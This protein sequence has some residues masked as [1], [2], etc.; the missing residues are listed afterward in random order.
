MNITTS[1]LKGLN[2]AQKDAITSDVPHLL[3]LAGAGSGKTRVLTHRIAWL[4]QEFGL[5][6]YSVLAVTFTNKAAAEMRHRLEDLLG[7]STSGLWV[8]TF[9]GIAH[10]M[11]RAHYGEAGLPQNFQILDADD[12]V[13]LIKRVLKDLGLDETQ[14]PAKQAAW[15][16]NSEKDEGRRPHHIPHHGDLFLKTMVRIYTAYEEA[17]ARGGM[18]DFAEILLR[19]H[20]L[21]LKNESILKGYQQ[22]FRQILVDEFQDT[23]AVQYAWLRLLVGEN[24]QLTVVGDDDQSIYGWRGAKITNIREFRK[25][26]PD[27]DIIRL[28][29]N[30]RSTAAILQ[31]ANAVIAHN[32][33]RL[34]KQLWTEGESGDPLQ[35]Y[36]AFNDLDEAQY[37]VQEIQRLVDNGINRREVAVLYRSNAQSRVLEEALIRVQMPYHIHGGLRFFER[38][39]I[40]N[41]V[42]Y[43]RQLAHPVD[44]T[45]FERVVNTP[46]RGI[47]ERTIELLRERA[48]RD[49]ISLWEAT[50]RILNEQVLPARAANALQGYVD[51]IREL[52]ASMGELPLHELIDTVIHRSGLWDHHLKE[53]GEKGQ[54]RTENL[55]ELVGAARE[56]EWDESDEL[57]TPLTAF[58]DHAAL[59]SGEAQAGEFEDAVQL[60]T[61]H[62]AKGLEFPVVFLAGM[63]EGLFPHEMALEDNNLEEERRLCYVGITRAMRRLYLTYAEIRRLYGNEKNT[64]P[65]RFLREIPAELMREVRLK[66]TPMASSRVGSAIPPG[67]AASCQLG[68]RVRHPRFG[69]GIILGFEGNGPNARVQVNFEELGAKWLVLQYARLEPV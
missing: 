54:T 13:R 37:I 7:I 8:G 58:L 10:R 21:M 46:V 12:Q 64:V 38:A 2:Q 40:K 48:R 67:G 4:C 3:V 61:L 14:W 24:G 17:C 62:S 66:T 60:M 50:A 51:L 43:L 59:E 1:L 63:E 49:Q 47:G 69:E 11:L 35:V 31:A 9:H 22:R 44:D 16:I 15:F 5:S 68:Q 6:P 19:A 39:E 42:A 65:S 30:Y 20:E 52:A 55:K 26:F 29:Q 32:K 56:F 36:C 18:I 34:G 45:A 33:D 57:M 41:A 27:A 25:D 23:N 53:K 28:E